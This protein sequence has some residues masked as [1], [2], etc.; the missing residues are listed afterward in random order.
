M[1]VDRAEKSRVSF[2]V[3]DP[4][5][6]DAWA[7]AEMASVVDSAEFDS[8]SGAGLAIVDQNSAG[9]AAAGPSSDV[10]FDGFDSVEVFELLQKARGR[11]S[12]TQ[13]R[14]GQYPTVLLCWILFFQVRVLVRRRF[15]S[16]LLLQPAPQLTS[17][18]RQTRHDLKLI[19]VQ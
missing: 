17:V 19:N 15:P 9:R 7:L 16:A 11:V 6:S 13:R 8:T 18:R 1:V 4:A 3:A 12:Q 14:L 10:V 2:D 5:S